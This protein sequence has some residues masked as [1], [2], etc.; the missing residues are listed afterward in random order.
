MERALHLTEWQVSHKEDKSFA[1]NG[2]LFYVDYQLS[3]QTIFP[4]A[5]IDGLSAS[6][7]LQADIFS[8][9]YPLHEAGLAAGGN[10]SPIIGL[11]WHRKYQGKFKSIVAQVPIL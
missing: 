11:E 3:L 8:S 5:I 1:P 7:F 4:R 10:L 2:I 6:S 9:Y